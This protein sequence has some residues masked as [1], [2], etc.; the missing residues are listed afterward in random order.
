M[1]YKLVM[2]RVNIFLFASLCNPPIAGVEP[3]WDEVAGHFLEVII[4]NIY[5]IMENAS[6]F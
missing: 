4:I 1:S 6:T 2:A 3:L 5:T